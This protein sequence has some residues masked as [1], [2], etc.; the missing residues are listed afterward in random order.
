MHQ[1]DVGVKRCFV[2]SKW[3]DEAAMGIGE[4]WGTVR[5]G[6]VIELSGGAWEHPRPPRPAETSR[7]SRTLSL[8]LRGGLGWR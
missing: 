4:D 5:C 1:I 6:V 7:I 2:P 3:M 8:E